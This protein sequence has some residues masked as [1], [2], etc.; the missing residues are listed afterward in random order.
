M[1]KRTL[2][3]KA[4]NQKSYKRVNEISKPKKSGIR[5]RKERVSISQKQNGTAGNISANQT[6]M[7]TPS[8]L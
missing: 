4:Q 8:E 7:T 1:D 5:N 6:S 3:E 2:H